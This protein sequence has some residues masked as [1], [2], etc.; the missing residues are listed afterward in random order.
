MTAERIK[1][2][3]HA[4]A[5]WPCCCCSCG[6][7]SS[8][9][10]T[11]SRSCCPS[12]RPSG[13]RSPTTPARSGR[14]AGSPARTRSSASSPARCCGVA[15]AMVASRFR[16]AGELLTPLAAAVNAMPIIVLAPIFNNMF[17]STSAIPRRLIVTIIVFFPIFV[18]T[19]R[20]LRPGRRHQDRADALLRR[21]RRGRSCARCGCPNALPFF[22]TGLKL[23]ASLG[24][25]AA[26]VAEYF[27]GL[28]NGLGS[29]ITSYAGAT[30]YP[31]AW[32]YVAAACVLGLVFYCLAARPR[33][34]RHAV[35]PGAAPSVPESHHQTTTG[36]HHMR[37]TMTASRRCSPERSRSS[38][39]R[40]AATTPARRRRRRRT[41]ARR[42]TTAA[43]G[44][45]A[46]TTAASGGADHGCRRPAQEGEAAAAVVH[47]G[48]VRR[49]L[50]RRRP[51]LLQEAGPRR[52]ASSRAASTSCRRPCWPRATPTSPSRGCPR[53]SRRA[54]RAPTSPTS[55]RSSSGR[56]RSRCSF[57]DK[58][59]TDRRRPQG[60]EG[61]Q[62]GLR[63]R[64]RAV[65]RHDQG[66]PRTRART[67][68]SCSSSST[69]RR[70]SAAT[71][72]PPRR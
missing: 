69:C 72:T 60:Q 71:S 57:K 28:Q 63:Q 15:A 9:G 37:R 27:G 45:A 11:S 59:I 36:D 40:A 41:A 7:S 70:C 29:R 42:P 67:S 68:R 38:P 43:A 44:T 51:G 8:S 12:R 33:A 34:A 48:P 23:A 13:T 2:V 50:R 16:I 35:A 32:A 39:P 46:T 53:R 52:R 22:F 65:R 3:R 31:R 62:L 55:P 61:R 6:S 1:A 47:P 19:L 17:S 26:V 5:S 14:R 25:I 18:N 66:R 30:T 64:V 10:A 56:A 54:S 4:A 24:V 20:G 58:D 49:L 21:Q